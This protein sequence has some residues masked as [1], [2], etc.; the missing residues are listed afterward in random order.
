MGAESR[1]TKPN[2]LT[3]WNVEPYML[4]ACLGN[5]FGFGNKLESLFFDLNTHFSIEIILL[6]VRTYTFGCL[7]LYFWVSELIL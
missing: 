3:I 4:D 5:H 2:T 7:N 6:H 1:A